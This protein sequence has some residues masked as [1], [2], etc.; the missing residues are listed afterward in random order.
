MGDTFQLTYTIDQAAKH[1]GLKVPDWE[2]LDYH[3]HVPNEAVT[4]QMSLYDIDEDKRDEVFYALAS[5]DEFGTERNFNKQVESYV[6]EFLTP[7]TNFGN[8][9]YH[10]MG[11]AGYRSFSKPV[12]GIHSANVLDGTLTITFDRDIVHVIHAMIDGYG[13]IGIACSDVD[14]LMSGDLGQVEEWTKTHI[15]WLDRYYKIYGEHKPKLDLNNIEDF[16]S[17]YFREEMTRIKQGN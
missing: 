12:V 7:F 1:F 17:K 15:H 9:E 3:A 8:V 13:A 10:C 5:A 14:D 11:D 4:E 2:S 6:E 16:D